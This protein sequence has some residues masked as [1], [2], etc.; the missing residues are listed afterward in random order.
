MEKKRPSEGGGEPSPKKPKVDDEPA[1]PAPL[2]IVFS[3][4]SAP[5]PPVVHEDILRDFIR[6]SC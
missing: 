4:A 2:V 3:A 5:S 6:S 1:A